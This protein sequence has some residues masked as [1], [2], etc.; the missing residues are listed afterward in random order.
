MSLKPKA[1]TFL[2]KAL[3]EDGYEDLNKVELYKLKTNTTVDP[4]EIK[5]ALQIVPR[6]IL[7]LLQ[8][9]LAPLGEN[10]NKEIKIPVEPEAFLR[11]TK[12]A[13]D[14]YSG[15]IHQDGKIISSFKYRS[16]PGVGLVVMSAFELYDI[17]DLSRM[18]KTPV[19][20]VDTKQIQDIIEEKLRSRD[21]I[22]KIVDQKLSEREAL[23]T[24]VNEKISQMLSEKENKEEVISKEVRKK[25]LKL[26]EFLEKKK[27]KKPSYEIKIEKSETVNCPDC[28]KKIFDG[29]GFSGCI[30]F[31]NDRNKKIHMKKSQ[32]GVEIS[33]SSQWD[34]ENIEMLVEVLREKSNRGK[35]E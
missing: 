1:I 2:K 33:F 3:G 20:S 16:L 13:N 24:L 9:E 29:S 19:S 25:K 26:K 11:V 27:N 12:F 18:G 34:S 30:C 4:E 8:K 35:Y 23:D 22:S 7:S 28:S 31:G 32:Q 21:M 17:E 10:G 5:T 6:T 14:V 15:D